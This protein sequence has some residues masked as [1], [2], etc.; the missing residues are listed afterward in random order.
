MRTVLRSCLAVAASLLLA[1]A[2]SAFAQGIGKPGNA[3]QQE[4]QQNNKA[5]TDMQS[6]TSQNT[7]SQTNASKPSKGDDNFMKKAAEDG[8]AEVQ[9][10]QLAAA[11]ASSPEVKQF[12]QMLVDD[13]TKANDE[14]KKLAADKGVTLPDKPSMSEQAEKARLER[15]SGPKFDKAFMDHVVK[16]H[17]ND[18]NAARDEIQSGHD[19]AVKDFANKILPKLEEHLKKAESVDTQVKTGKAETSQP[20][21]SAKNTNKPKY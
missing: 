8:L 9:L 21:Q 20:A 15:T 10:G 5:G 18:V 3:N 13:H 14:L 6:S 17:Q 1:F 7:A 16:D 4:T 12:A 2:M 11:K 19:S